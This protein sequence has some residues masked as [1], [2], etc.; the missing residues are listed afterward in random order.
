MLGFRFSKFDAS[1]YVI[2]YQNGQIRRE[3]RGL[4]FLYYVPN[5]TL[6]A[7]PMGSSDAPFMFRETTADYQ[8][9][10]IQGQ[11]T[12]KIENPVQLA[13]LLDFTVDGSGKY[14][15]EDHE[16][17]AQRLVN[18]AQTTI[19]SV[20]ENLSL[21][22]TIRSSK[23]LEKQIMEGLLNAPAIKMLGILPLSAHVLGIKS[24]P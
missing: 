6:V 4:S 12:Y 17:L 1:T 11:V 14:V 20:I 3:G 5:S 7:I 9:V 16:K 8:T 21:R 18:E 24:I 15:S 19:A 23:T 22:E 2:Q 13:D 10:S